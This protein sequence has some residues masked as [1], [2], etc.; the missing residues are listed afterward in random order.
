MYLGSPDSKART[1]L[2]DSTGWP[3]F[4]PPGYLLFQRAT[5]LLAQALKPGSFDLTGE[6]LVVME[7]LTPGNPNFSRPAFSASRNGVLVTRLGGAN[8]NQLWWFARSSSEHPK[9][10]AAQEYLNPRL[11]PDG[12]RVAGGQQESGGG[13]IWLFDLARNTSTRFTFTDA[14]DSSPIW[15]PDG[16]RIAFASNRDG[17]NGIYVKNAGAHCRRNC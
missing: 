10:I 12:Q 8:T 9:M 11:S 17:A 14:R 3:G 15:S 5:T 13:D 6:P 1:K 7:G 2:V 4:S 16:Q